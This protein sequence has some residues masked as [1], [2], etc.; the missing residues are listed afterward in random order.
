[1]LKDRQDIELTNSDIQQLSNRDALTAF[2]ARLGYDTNHRLVQNLAA[3]DITSDALKNAITHIERLA[4]EERYFEIYLFELKSVTVSTTNALVRTFRNRSGDYL[5]VLTH[6][7]ERLDFVLV[8]RYNTAQTPQPETLD[9]LSIALPATPIQVS[10][11]PR[12]LSVNRR[13]PEPV[14]L[15][16]LRRFSYTESDI[17]A[18][19]D[20]LISAYDIADW[21][22]PFFNNRALFSDYYLTE[23]LPLDA[24]WNNPADSIALTSAFRTLRALYDGVRTTYNNQPAPFVQSQLIEPVLAALGFT[25]QSAQPTRTS[26]I[27]PTYMLTTSHAPSSSDTPIA[28]CLAY[29]WNRSLDGKDDRDTQSPDENPGASVVTLLER[30]DAPWA[31]VTNGKTWRLYSAKAHSRATN[32]YEIDLEET[33]AMPPANLE[34][35]FRYFWLLFRAA[36]FTLDANM[37]C[38]LDTLLTES[39][40]YARELGERLKDRV[41]EDIFPHFARGFINYA[42]QHNQ[43]P[44]N[45]DELDAAERNTLLEPYFSGTLTFLYRLLFLLYA[46]SRDLLPLRELHGYYPHSL[47]QLKRQIAHHAGTIQDEAP[48]N[49]KS[50]YHD[51][52]TRLYD[53]LQTLFQAVDKGDAAL[54]VPV[55][56]GG[57]FVTN[58]DP[59]DPSPEATVARFLASHKIPDR[60]LALGLDLMARDLDDKRHDLVFIDYKSLGV[61]QLGSIYE[62]LLEFK[63]RVAPEE[64]I[65]I[66]GKKAEEIMPISEAR[67]KNLLT[68]RPGKASKLNTYPKGHVY[69]ENDR[70]ERKASGSYYTPDYIVKYIVQHTVGPI[71]TQKFEDLRPLFREAQ[72]ALRVERDKARALPRLNA[73]P[74]LETYKKYRDTLNEAF[75]DLKVLDPAM[76]SGHFLV[77]AVDYI[78]DQMAT[79]LTAFTWNPVV[80]ALSR[81]RRDI[82]QEMERQGIT[83]DSSKLTDINLLKR[84]VLKRCI[85]GVD[86]NPMAVELAKVSLWLDCFT[87]GA[88]L[89]FLDHHMKPGNS[90]I[91]GNVQEVQDALSHDLFGHQFAGL[92]NATQMMRHVGELSDVTAQ[93]VAES[94]QAYKGAYDALAPF[95]RL[96]DVWISEYFGNKGAKR[97]VQSYAEAIIAANYNSLNAVDR[98]AIKTAL[99]LAQT[100]HFFHWELEFPEV[101][102]DA[103]KRKANGGFDA[104]IGNPPYVRQEGLGDDKPAFKAMYAVFNSIA[105]LYTYFIERGNTLLHCGGRFGMITAN[106]FMRANYGAALRLFLTT[107]VKLETLIDFG[108]LRVF[109]DAATDPLITLSSKNIPSDH[110]TYVR[111]KSLNFVSLASAI[112]NNVVELP[113]SALNGSNWSLAIDTQQAIL[114]KLKE[115]SIPL[116][117]YTGG[118]IRRG[119]V[120][121]LNDA[122]IV[123]EITR[124]RLLTEDSN[125]AE[126]IKPFLI[127]DDIKHYYLDFKHK[128][129]IF[130]RRGI[131]LTKFKAIKQHLLQYKDQLE[132]RPSNWDEKNQGKW[133]GRKPGLYKW[134]EIQD[135]IAYFAE[136]ERPKVIYPDMSISSKFALDDQGYYSGN[137]TYI[138]PTSNHYLLAL[139]NS[140]LIWVYLK[141]TCSVLGDADERGRLRLFSIFIESI[142]IRRITFTLSPDQRATYL[143]HAINLDATYLD[144]REH[145]QQPMLA[146]V[147]HHLAQHPEQSDVVHD[148]LA[149]LAEEMIRLNKE[150]RASMQQFLSWL[151]S[152]LHILPD[153]EGRAGIDVLTGK[154]KLLDFPGDYQKGEPPLTTQEIEDILLKNKNKLGVSLNDTALI[155]RVKREYEGSLEHILPLKEKLELTD[156]LIDAVVYRL[157]G[158]TEEEIA[159][160]EGKKQ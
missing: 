9:P 37:P 90:L 119:I 78:T 146:F 88:P 106:K 28:L 24:V 103:S 124:N 89:S 101:F 72:Q 154:S 117:E 104:V 137:T 50:A 118:K 132:P 126:I 10:I 62:G 27:E 79:F 156:H 97:T 64:M 60:H 142:P 73:D 38:F 145:D 151:P 4:S 115:N 15:R 121:G 71:L 83:I 56:N 125:S 18:Q 32:Y 58:P 57:L 116:G 41:F 99:T 47:E 107:Q 148:L 54:N 43:L 31:I 21:S 5:L 82:Q 7:Y 159:V 158:L 61:R 16:V 20:K 75:F 105:D 11:R 68:E 67:Q 127:G 155:E 87:L 80:Y 70:R 128:Y 92:L 108:E 122:F 42:R 152:T 26:T 138:I 1:M 160:V 69:L 94:R 91:G 23:R 66:K 36:A 55:Y 114:D 22:E 46:E 74:E 8:Q 59:A 153:R 34:H 29:F 134:F 63:L 65:I 141:K 30:G 84:Q 33:L 98:T 76:G 44:A 143:D 40:R 96:L 12:V 157:Y 77:E 135:D 86:L 129:I 25:F 95:K 131:D 17:Y 120:T 48:A 123:D 52:S 93:E 133:R 112:E 109:G 100:K 113:E 49:I 111:I 150:K 147:D 2:F 102:Y 85:Y 139:L 130:T 19:Y 110:V 14:D 45:L 149:H 136:F 53:D 6:E 51:L 140:S 81:T 13:K 144:D 3:M 35:A 39:E